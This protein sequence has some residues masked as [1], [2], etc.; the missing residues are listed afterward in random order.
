MILDRYNLTWKIESILPLDEIKL[1]YRKLMMNDTYQHPG[2]WHDV[3]LVP[4]LSRYDPNHFVMSYMIK[5]LDHHSVYEA[6]VQ[7]RNFYG[8]NEVRINKQALSQT[9]YVPFFRRLQLCTHPLSL[10][11]QPRTNPCSQPR[12]IFIIRAFFFFTTAVTFIAFLRIA[13]PHYFA[14]RTDIV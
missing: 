11:E 9:F 5:K 7:A 14:C 2:R 1:L 12:L 10:L 13:K 8:W 3:I 6:M 4:N